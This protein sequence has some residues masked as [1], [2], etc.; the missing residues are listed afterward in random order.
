MPKDQILERLEQR[1]SPNDRLQ[2]WA[3]LAMTHFVLWLI[4]ETGKQHVTGRSDHRVYRLNMF[5]EKKLVEVL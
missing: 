3:V 2:A 5:L 1:V 4:S